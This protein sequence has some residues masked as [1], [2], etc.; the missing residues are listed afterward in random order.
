[1]MKMRQ[2]RFATVMS[3]I[4]WFGFLKLSERE[5][6]RK[7]L[8]ARWNRVAAA[9]IYSFTVHEDIVTQQDKKDKQYWADLA[10]GQQH[11]LEALAKGYASD[12]ALIYQQHYQK[13]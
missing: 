4:D 10:S 2:N 8:T 1:M 7:I 13:R 12:V 5:I 11:M 9:D 3:L 6:N